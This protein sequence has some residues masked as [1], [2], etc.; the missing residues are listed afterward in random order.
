[1]SGD[2]AGLEQEA[3]RARQT[4]P[5]TSHKAGRRAS[6]F[7]APHRALILAS[8]MY[9]G[10]ADIYEIAFRTG[11]DHVAVARRMPELRRIGLAEPTGKYALTPTGC[12]ARMWRAT[13]R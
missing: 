4:D 12:R 6:G 1:M 7:A 10:E 9:H 13:Q 8:L 11:L 5:S 2:Q 3:P